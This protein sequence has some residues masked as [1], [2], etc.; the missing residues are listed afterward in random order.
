MRPLALPAAATDSSSSALSG[1]I[2]LSSV[3]VVL[4]WVFMVASP[5]SM[6]ELVFGGMQR[7]WSRPTGYE[8]NGDRPASLNR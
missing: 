3:E 7:R 6:S 8:L 5:V 4:S 1:R 2:W